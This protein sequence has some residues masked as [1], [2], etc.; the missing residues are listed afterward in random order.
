MAINELQKQTNTNIQEKAKW[1]HEN[2]L[3]YG[4]GYVS[5]AWLPF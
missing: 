4:N 2:R 3:R 5:D 1:L